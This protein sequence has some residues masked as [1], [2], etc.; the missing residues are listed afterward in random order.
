MVLIPKDLANMKGKSKIKIV[1]SLNNEILKEFPMEDSQAAY[2]Y[3][4]QMEGYGLEIKI[5][6]PTITE[7]LAES[8]GLSADMKEDL[9]QSVI[10]ELE[11][12]DGSCC[13]GP[14]EMPTEIEPKS[15]Q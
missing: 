4:A 14:A 11:E 8:L 13:A 1:D 9:R 5:V 7:T 10:A 3:A 2:E 6:S 15:L 12:H